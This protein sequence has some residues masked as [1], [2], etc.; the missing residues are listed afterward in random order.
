MSEKFTNELILI[1]KKYI[2][3]IDIQNPI[4][5]YQIDK[6][7]I[8]I[9]D[10][11]DFLIPLKSI[12][13]INNCKNNFI[14]CLKEIYSL[15]MKTSEILYQSSKYIGID[16]SA[17]LSMPQIESFIICLFLLDNN[18]ANLMFR[19]YGTLST[20]TQYFSKQRN[21]FEIDLSGFLFF[22]LSSSANYIGSSC[23][24][25]LASSLQHDSSLL[26]LYL[27]CLLFFPFIFFR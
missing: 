14:E 13:Q 7:I 12:F 24:Q 10:I 22:L 3:N 25:A 18:Y 21:T 8:K 6:L 17:A 27:A 23:A 20:L 2:P 19:N 1:L 11:Y 26:S 4:I 15:H 9:S 16:L 5:K